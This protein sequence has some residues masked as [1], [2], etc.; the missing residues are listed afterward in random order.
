[1]EGFFVDNYDNIVGAVTGQLAGALYGLSTIPEKWVDV[2]AW[3]KY[4]FELADGLYYKK[5]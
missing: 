4:I 3:K 5:D 2:L 1:M